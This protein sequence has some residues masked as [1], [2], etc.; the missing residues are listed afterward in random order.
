MDVG[1]FNRSSVA[2]APW[3]SLEELTR[4]HENLLTAVERHDKRDPTEA[5]L[6]AALLEVD[7]QL[8][9]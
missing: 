8:R 4:V 9:G 1:D 2:R 7:E 5:L 3:E 6:P